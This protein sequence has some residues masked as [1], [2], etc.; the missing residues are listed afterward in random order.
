MSPPNALGL[1]TIELKET[2][3]RETELLSELR[4]KLG[5]AAEKDAAVAEAG[6]DRGRRRAARWSGH[7]RGADE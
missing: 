5:E 2:Q 3:N 7:D 1:V 4:A 6:S